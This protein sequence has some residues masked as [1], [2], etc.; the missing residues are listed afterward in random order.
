M[1]AYTT[2]VPR[3]GA[4]WLARAPSLLLAAACSLLTARPPE[5]EVLSVMLRG[6]GPLNQA[7]AVELCVSNPNSVALA[8]RSVTAVVD[9]NGAVLAEGASE[10]AVLLQPHSSTV[11]S[12]EV[13]TTLRNLGMQ[14]NGISKTGGLDYR[15]HGTVEL[16]GS[17]AIAV[18]YS[19]QGRLGLLSAMQGALTDAA[20]PQRTQCRPELS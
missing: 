13:V 20:A 3:P 7:L 16:T 5:V 12:F 11:V 9:V 15:I 17:L 6:V 8:F 2:R 19:H 18:P 10:A 14:L 1:E 4:W